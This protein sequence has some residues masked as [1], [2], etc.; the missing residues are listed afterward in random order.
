V[1]NFEVHEAKQ[2]A[3][4]AVYRCG[5]PAQVPKLLSYVLGGNEVDWPL[6]DDIPIANDKT[7]F[8]L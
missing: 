6:V 2:D 5:D 3:A 4:E 7:H 8:Y 1:T